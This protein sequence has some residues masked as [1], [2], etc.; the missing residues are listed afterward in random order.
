MQRVRSWRMPPDYLTD[1]ACHNAL[2][3]T[4]TNDLKA[5]WS[6]ATTKALGWEALKAV[7]RGAC[8]SSTYGVRRQL[9]ATL[10]SKEHRLAVLQ[11]SGVTSQEVRQELLQVRT[12]DGDLVT[13]HQDVLEVF[14]EL[15][16]G[17][18]SARAV[19]TLGQIE[20]YLDGLGLPRLPPGLLQ[21]LACEIHMEE[22]GVAIQAL[23]R[24][25]VPDADGF[26]AKFYQV[27]SVSLRGK[28]LEVLCEARD[29]GIL[30]RTMREH[31]ICLLPKP[32]RDATDPS[33]YRPLTMLSTDIKILSKVLASRLSTVVHT[34]VH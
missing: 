25:K 22:L 8:M 32:G 1:S 27:Y 6:S 12:S 10:G 15:L 23:S 33:S 30:P 24:S 14:V 34:L 21:E 13:N 26:P 7:M 9:E 31:I 20:E 2:A 16:C 28:L 29:I 17:V 11:G 4:L 5:N 3:S 19:G 18:Y